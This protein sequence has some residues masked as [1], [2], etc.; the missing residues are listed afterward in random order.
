M[1]LLHFSPPD[2]WLETFPKARLAAEFAVGGYFRHLPG[3]FFLHDIAQQLLG[4]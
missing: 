1:L 2:L 4:L 3:Y